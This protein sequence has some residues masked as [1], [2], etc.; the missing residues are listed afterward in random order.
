MHLHLS[1]STASRNLGY[2]IELLCA[3]VAHPEI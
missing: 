1:H 2:M 3:F